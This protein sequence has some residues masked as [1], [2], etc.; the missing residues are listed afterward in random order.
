MDMMPVRHVPP[1]ELARM[2]YTSPRFQKMF[3]AMLLCA[4]AGV[5]SS[6][7]PEERP[8]WWRTPL[9]M[10]FVWQLFVLLRLQLSAI[11]HGETM[12]DLMRRMDEVE[13]RYWK[14]LACQDEGLAERHRRDHDQLIDEYHEEKS[15]FLG[16]ER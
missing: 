16:H 2:V 4:A 5:A 10:I 14:A 6:F 15:R 13:S 7:I 11:P 9:W 12:Q 3:V 8:W 1:R